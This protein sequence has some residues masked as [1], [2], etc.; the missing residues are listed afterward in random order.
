MGGKTLWGLNSLLTHTEQH[1]FEGLAEV[2][3][4][5]LLFYPLH[6]FGRE[7]LYL[8][9]YIEYEICHFNHFRYIIQ[10]YEYIQMLCNYHH[11]PLTEVPYPQNNNYLPPLPQLLESCTLLCI[12][13]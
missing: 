6:H 12:S 5:F 2:Q 7:F 3:S 10:W 9:K 8:I 11:Y 1:V 4:L 13:T